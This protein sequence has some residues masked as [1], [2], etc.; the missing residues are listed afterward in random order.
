MIHH[1]SWI[2]TDTAND[3]WLD[4][5][6]VGADRWR[7]PGTHDWAIAKRTLHGGLREGV[8]VVEVNNGA[9]SFTVLPT[10]GMGL[11]RGRYRGTFLGWQS[12]V[13]GPVHPG[14]VNLTERGGLG[15]LN[16]FDEWICRCGLAWN[17][18]PGD[19]AT[20]RLTLHGRIANLPAHYVE[21]RV[22]LEA[23]HE[24][25]VVGSVDETGLFGPHLRLT[26]TYTTLPGSNRLVIHDVVENRGGS[27]AEVQML[28]HCNVGAP[29]LEAGS[30]VLVPLREVAP[31]D[32][33]AVEG[34]ATYD[35]FAAPHAG[36]AEQVYY[37]DP[38]ADAAG[39]TLVLLC[40]R[41]AERGLV[42]RWQRSELP[43][44]AVWKNTAAVED[45]YVAGLEPAT[46]YPNFKS[47]ERQRG[48]V[49]QL[50]PGGKWQCTWAIEV[51]DTAAGVA[52]VLTEVA[53]MQAK[54]PAAVHKTPQA[55]FSP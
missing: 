12:P 50:P 1:K 21:A 29:F 22:G 44:L 32:A 33:R 15:W 31:R 28:Y 8:E 26:T 23:P 37:Y 5:F 20:G 17:G 53:R 38:L 25:S 3:V 34:V 18:P 40:N 39:H 54:A 45:G 27:P 7:L 52:G 19:D 49:R 35:T 43:C 9:L 36:F 2:L 51:H 4:S 13:H 16:G 6:H 48:R 55:V 10:R 47:F 14:F 30:R 46:N 24:L 42:V 41:P 11:W